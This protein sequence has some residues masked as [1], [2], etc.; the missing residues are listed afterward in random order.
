MFV[1]GFTFIRNAVR[2]DFPVVE[3]IG[4]V[5]PLCDEFVVAVGKSDDGTLELIQ[6]IGSPKIRIVETV[7]DESLRDGGAVYAHETNKAL[8]AIS[9]QANWAFYVQG[10]E[11]LHQ[12]YLPTIKIAMENWQNDP[13]IDGLLLD[14]LHFYGSYDYLG[15]SP[16]WYRREI[17]II[18][19]DPTI[20][21]YR[22]AQGFRKGQNQKL[23]VKPTDAQMYHY[24][25]VKD[26]RVMQNK[27]RAVNKYWD[28]ATEAQKAD[29]VAFDYS[30]ID[31]LAKFEGTHPQIMQARI[32]QKNWQFTHDITQKKLTLRYRLNMWIEQ[33]TGWRIGEYRN[34]KIT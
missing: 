7:W 2:F 9:P 4:S 18:K 19:N 14:Y 31:S 33:L 26:P 16:A 11:V 23:R 34:Y 1:S 27:Q 24:G 13:N 5:L 8:R 32:A 21:S 30:G 25:W 10:D 6:Q 22:D 15:D 20:Y 3:A 28:N 17:R 29:I 12:K